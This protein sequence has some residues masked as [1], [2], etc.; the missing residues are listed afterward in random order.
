MD[1]PLVKILIASSNRYLSLRNPQE[2]VLLQEQIVYMNLE[3]PPIL[4]NVT[5]HMGYWNGY[6]ARR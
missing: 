6:T 3:S 5:N 2:L 1:L 4:F